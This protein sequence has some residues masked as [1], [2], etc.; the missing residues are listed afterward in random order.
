[1]C[2]YLC[3]CVILIFSACKK[4]NFILSPTLEEILA[5]P[6]DKRNKALYGFPVPSYFARGG[7]PRALLVAIPSCSELIGFV[8]PIQLWRPH[9]SSAP[10]SPLPW[11]PCGRGR[12]PASGV[13]DWACACDCVPVSATA[14]PLRL[15]RQPPA[16]HRHPPPLHSHHR[17]HVVCRSSARRPPAANLTPLQSIGRVACFFGLNGLGSIIHAGKFKL[18]SSSELEGIEGEISSFLFKFSSIPKEIWVSKL[19][20]KTSGWTREGSSYLLL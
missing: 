13:G 2:H 5:P 19:A 12:P 20:Y 11:R 16:H 10:L 6:I 8:T 9:C 15:Y 4:I 1:M 18:Q 7:A 17:C 14:P 3:I